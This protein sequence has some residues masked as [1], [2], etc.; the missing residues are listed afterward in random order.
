MQEP[1]RSMVRR[2]RRSSDEIVH[3]SSEIATGA[4]DLSSRTEQAAANLEQSAAAMETISSTVKTTADHTSEATHVARHNAEVAA[5]GGRAMRE[6]VTTM[7]GIRSSSARVVEIIGTIDGIAFQTHILA[8]NAT[9]EAARAGEPGR[10]F[11]VVA[12]EVQ[13]L[14]QRGAEAARE[15]K[16]LIGRRGHEGSGTQPGGRGGP[17]QEAGRRRPGSGARW[18]FMA[19]VHQPA[20]LGNEGFV[21]RRVLPAGR[22]RS[23]ELR[24]HGPCVAQHVVRELAHR[25]LAGLDVP[26][27][28][29][30]DRPCTPQA[31]ARDSA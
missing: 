28:D 13:M 23:P 7:E 16:A 31:A 21:M 25:A 24:R 11:A 10:G 19:L 12:S 9:V 5:Q 1:L 4:M 20:D 2:V 14:A 18:G 8:L 27:L 15:I 26:R 6:V 29:P 22:C 30:R 3:S 17:L